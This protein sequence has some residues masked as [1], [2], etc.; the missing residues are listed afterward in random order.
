MNVKVLYLWPLALL[1][2]VPVIIFMYLLKQKADKKEVP[3]LF[4]WKETYHNIEA[5]TPWEKLKKNW[6]MILQIILFLILIFALMGPYLLNLGKSTS[7]VVVI[8]DNS[9]SMN[10][11]YEGEKT[12]FDKAITE[13]SDY[14]KS[15]RNGTGISVIASSSEATLVVTSTEDKDEAIEK[16]KSIQPT[17]NPGSAHAGVE[18]V[19]TMQSQWPALTTVCFTDSNV[20]MDDVDGY[21][22]DVY[23]Q[24][25]N[26][27]IDYLSHGDSSEKL[28]V[29][30]KVTN[31]GEKETA[32][33][34]TLYGDD[35][36]LSEQSVSFGPGESKIVYFDKV[37]FKGNVLR[38]E[39]NGNDSLEE[40]N[41]SYDIVSEHKQINVLLMTQ[42]NAY[43]EKALDLMEGISV[44]KSN[45]IESFDTFVTQDFDLYIFDNMRPA[46]FPE[47]GNVIIFESEYASLFDG[48]LYKTTGQVDGAL[49]TAKTTPITQYVDNMDFSAAYIWCYQTPTWAETFLTCESEDG[50]ENVGFYGDYNGQKITVFGFDI[51]NSE[52]PLKMEFPLLMYN[53]VN[54][55]VST[56]MLTTNVVSVGDGVQ[57]NAKADGGLPKVFTPD[58]T[59]IELSDYRLAFTNT[60]VPGVYTV[61]QSEDR[62]TGDKEYFAVNFPS[63]ESG[64]E[65]LPSANTDENTDVKKSATADL[66]LK[67]IIIAI[68][69]L[70]LGVEWIA[71]LRK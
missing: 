24:K 49:V 9:G 59:A 19:K 38:A 20:S 58:D 66:D 43:L 64:S 27:G 71:Y 44:T 69:L 6:L 60:D 46:N 67:N 55:N 21:I 25:E 8:V 15:L 29:L 14:V 45:D 13:A 62:F 48:F 54:D 28:I 37:N 68:I 42:K 52:L 63:G 11:L 40:D 34:V 33:Q 41:V 3:S 50:T 57:I 47:R 30:A 16:I 4:L 31:Y 7:H 17:L 56:G 12:R 36:I 23:K 53:I 61:T 51:H 26:V 35:Q 10:A 32:R 2:L 1:A 70:L 22:V 39:L 65:A 5:N 18:M